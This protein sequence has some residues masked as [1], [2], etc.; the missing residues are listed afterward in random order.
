MNPGS[1]ASAVGRFD[2]DAWLAARGTTWPPDASCWSTLVTSQP[3]RLNLCTCRDALV[4]PEVELLVCSLQREQDAAG[5][6]FVTHTVLYASRGG[7]LQAVLDVPT[8]AMLDDCAPKSP[9]PC[10]VALYLRVDGDA[11]RLEDT[12]GMA[13]ACDHPW[14]ASSKPVPGISDWNSA[15]GLRVRATYRR[16]CDSRGRYRWE[17]DAL[18]RAP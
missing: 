2:Q 10:R 1:S 16:V 11:I 5:V 4:L 17:R 9:I 13:S 18:R 6:P 8:G 12:A 15:S 14:V 3:R 7:V